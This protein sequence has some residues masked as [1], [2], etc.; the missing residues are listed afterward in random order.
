MNVD[1]T[2]SVQLIV[3]VEQLAK[4]LL[5]N[6][7]LVGRWHTQLAMTLFN[8]HYFSESIARYRQ[9]LELQPDNWRLQYNLAKALGSNEDYDEAVLISS[10]LLDN[11]EI[12][13]EYWRAL[14]YL[15][16]TWNVAR[17]ELASA[18]ALF[19][20]SLEH[21][22]QHRTL[23]EHAKTAVLWLTRVL[24]EQGKFSETVHLLED[25][26]EREVS[27]E[28]SCIATLFHHWCSDDKFHGWL[29]RAAS[30]AQMLEAVLD[31]YEI[32]IEAARTVASSFNIY[33][34]LRLHLGRLKWTS[35]SPDSQD[36][37]LDL[38]EE[39]I[40]QKAP[41]GFDDYSDTS[42]TRTYTVRHL[43]PA[44]LSKAKSAGLGAPIGLKA[45]RYTE[46]LEN[47]VNLSDLPALSDS[48]DPH[49]TLGK[50]R[51][52]YEMF[53]RHKLTLYSPLF[54]PSISSVP[55][56]YPSEENYTGVYEGRVRSS[57]RG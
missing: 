25:L 46:R 7:D 9:A 44:L 20:R 12:L 15:M 38:W 32:A 26:A 48:K 29:S 47:L 45:I 39:S 21:G 4:S 18:E 31:K 2:P 13:V 40:H 1:D 41:E 19:K 11:E 8:F 35:T 23:D 16:G 55:E 51:P 17:K 3:D 56:R 30:R 27:D 43:A 5:A 53:P 34:Q 24:N 50:L 57:R 37:A 36:A 6:S 54:S 42:W 22:L 10:R 52:I 49:L 28:V 33:L 14:L